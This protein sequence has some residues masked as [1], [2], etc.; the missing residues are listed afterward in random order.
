[1]GNRIGKVGEKT[2]LMDVGL[3]GVSVSQYD[4]I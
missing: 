4:L 1:M 3:D 2:G